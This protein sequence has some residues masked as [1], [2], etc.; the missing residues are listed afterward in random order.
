MFPIFAG[1]FFRAQQQLTAAILMIDMRSLQCPASFCPFSA[2]TAL[3]P[4]FLNYTIIFLLFSGR[5]DALN[6]SC[7]V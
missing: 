4:P 3:S 5:P 6:E 1:L 7:G 2:F